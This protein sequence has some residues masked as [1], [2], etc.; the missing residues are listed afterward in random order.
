VF[1]R[2]TAEARQAVVQAQ[3]EARTFKHPYIGV[4][5]VLIGMLTIENGPAA[6][7]LATFQVDAERARRRLG[8]WIGPGGEELD[9]DAL[10]ALGIDLDQVRRAT[11]E[12]FGPGALDRPRRPGGNKEIKGHIP[13]TPRAKKCLELALREAIT[14]KHNFISD[15]HLLLGI[16]RAEPNA[17]TKL[18]D[19][20]GVPRAELREAVIRETRNLAA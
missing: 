8:D 18:L 10:A 17:G 14:L 11:E 19:Q 20:L 7:A 4:E 13:F 16:L 15:G 1:E 2:F 12:V 9:A 5:H 3:N 6:R